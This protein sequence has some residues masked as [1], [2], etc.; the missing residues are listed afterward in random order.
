[1]LLSLKLHFLPVIWL[2]LNTSKPISSAKQRNSANCSCHS[3][4][5]LLSGRCCPEVLPCILLGLVTVGQ[6]F[7]A[8]TWHPQLWD[9]CMFVCCCLAAALGRFPLVC[10]IFL[11]VKASSSR[12]IG[13]V[14]VPLSKPQCLCSSNI[15]V[16]EK[17]VCLKSC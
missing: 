13:F 5:A 7:S 6:P 9:M 2:K 12:G 14:L 15:V 8:H 11:Y 16:K 17:D 4:A 1:M 10:S 3:Q